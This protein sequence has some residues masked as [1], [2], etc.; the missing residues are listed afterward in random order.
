MLIQ[1]QMYIK[2]KKVLQLKK[3]KSGQPIP[4]GR[5]HL[6]PFKIRAHLL[7]H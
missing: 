2:L 3:F 4:I 5:P 6:Y 7:L 1:T